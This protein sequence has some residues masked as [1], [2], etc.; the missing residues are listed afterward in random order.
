MNKLNKT[1]VAIESA[2]KENKKTVI[3]V[4]GLFYSERANVKF[5]TQLIVREEA[6]KWFVAGSKTSLQISKLVYACMHFRLKIAIGK[7]DS[8]TFLPVRPKSKKPERAKS[9]P[10]K[11]QKTSSEVK[12]YKFLSSKKNPKRYA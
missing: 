9:V 6:T 1:S 11:F 12:F 8:R 7:E 3:I 5:E 10:F 4:V 2:L